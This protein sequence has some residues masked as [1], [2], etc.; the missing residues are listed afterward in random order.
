MGFEYMNSS[1]EF[2]LSYSSSN[3]SLT[4]QID[5]IAIDDEIC[6]F[7]ECKETST[8]DKTKQWKIDLESMNGHF[9]GLCNEITSRFGKRKFKYVFA[10]KNYLVGPTDLDRIKDF[11]FSYFDEDTVRYYDG[12]ATHLGVAS[13]YQLLGN[14]FSGLDIK[15]LDMRVPAIEGKMGKHRYY[16]FSIEPSKLLKIAYV[17]HRNNANHDL[18]PMYPSQLV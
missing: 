11:R 4:K 3:P 14:I 9:Q 7:V 10:T 13:K 17:L 18:M 2:K 1:N 12:L 6:L 5:V 15:N 8:L 16:S